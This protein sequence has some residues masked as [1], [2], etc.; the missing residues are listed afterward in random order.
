MSSSVTA[1]MEPLAAA[2]CSAVILPDRVGTAAIV[3]PTA[4]TRRTGREGAPGA[5]PGVRVGARAEQRFD[6]FMRVI[7]RRIDQRSHFIPAHGGAG[8]GVSPYQGYL[9]TGTHSPYPIQG[10]P[11]KGKGGGGGGGGLAPGGRPKNN[12]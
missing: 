11:P 8:G 4:D 5:A 10:C 3:R 6:D 2:M 1:S 12:F 9:R 7:C